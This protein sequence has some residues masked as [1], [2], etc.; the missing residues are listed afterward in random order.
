VQH[1]RDSGQI[2]H[3]FQYPTLLDATRIVDVKFVFLKMIRKAIHPFEAEIGLLFSTDAMMADPRNHCVPLYDVLQLPDN[4]D[5]LI[6]V[7][8]LL[9]YCHSPRFDTVG[10]AV[11]YFRQVFEASRKSLL[12]LI[13]L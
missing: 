12:S 5:T 1:E 13:C 6:L 2:I 10:E 8:P 11:E 9:R 3:Y 7:M 4:E